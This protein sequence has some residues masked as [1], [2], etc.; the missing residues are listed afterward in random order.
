MRMKPI[1]LTM[2]TI[3]L[4]LV[5]GY[6]VDSKL[7]CSDDGLSQGSAL[8]IANERLRVKFNGH[9]IEREFKLEKSQLD[10]DRSWL[11]YY[12]AADCSIIIS[13]DRCG[14][15]DVGGISQGCP[16]R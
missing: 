8:S 2:S 3:A 14:V 5:A 4:L 9:R 12:Q 11:F 10:D 15:A 7:R 1:M 16:S 13:V 6:A